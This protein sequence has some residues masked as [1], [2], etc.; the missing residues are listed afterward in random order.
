MLGTLMLEIGPK[1]DSLS[2]TKIY[3]IVQTLGF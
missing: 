1:S 2:L 3:D